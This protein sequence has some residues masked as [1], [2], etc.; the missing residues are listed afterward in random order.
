MK[1][2][3]NR[4]SYKRPLTFQGDFSTETQTIY[5]INRDTKMEELSHTQIILPLF[6]LGLGDFVVS[7]GQASTYWISLPQVKETATEGRRCFSR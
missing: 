3:I 1:F 7:N 2:Y 4:N 6:D 5:M